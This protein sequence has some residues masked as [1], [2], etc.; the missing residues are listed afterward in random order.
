MRRV[1]AHPLNF[2]VKLVKRLHFYLRLLFL[3]QLLSVFQVSAYFRPSDEPRLRKPSSIH[4]HMAKIL[5]DRDK[6]TEAIDELKKALHSQPKN[7]G[8]AVKLAEIY[9]NNKEY[10][11]ALELLLPLQALSSRKHNIFLYLG[12]VYDGSEDYRSAYIYYKKAFKLD[13]TSYRSKLKIAQLFIKR[14]LF[15]DAAT[16][17]KNLLEINPDYKPAKVE[18]DLT[19]RLIKENTHNIFRRGSLVITFPDYNLIRDIE[20]WY[21][22]LQ[23]KIYYL[24]NA[25]GVYDQVVWLKIVDKVPT[26]ASPPALFRTMEDKIYLTVDSLK[27]KYTSL[28]THELTYLFF[29]RMGVRK[30]PQWLVEGLALYFSQPNLLKNMNLRRVRAGL[31]LLNEQFFPDKRYLHFHQLSLKEKQDLFHAFLIAKYFVVHYGWDNIQKLIR[32]F[33]E[34]R[35][36][37]EEAIWEVLHIT[38]KKLETDFD[39]FVMTQHFFKS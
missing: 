29:H 37:N 30:A 8:L 28:F 20:E 21:P 6:S 23:E 36:S 34:G 18:F 4:A 22:Y 25:L 2:D 14:G 5:L 39:V 11:K 9:Y 19:L 12:L 35:F 13:P 1:T 33:G 17:L 31:N 32:K 10:A 24:Q 26:N 15:Y 3:F 38:L 16:H 7:R 27:R